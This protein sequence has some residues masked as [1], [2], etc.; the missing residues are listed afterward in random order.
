MTRFLRTN[1]NR[2]LVA[3]I[4]AASALILISIGQLTE[5][6]AASCGLSATDNNFTINTVGGAISGSADIN[7]ACGVGANATGGSATAVGNIARATGAQAT[8]VGSDAR[9]TKNGSTAIGSLSRATGKDSTAIGI[10]AVADSDHS[11]SVG[12]TTGQASGPQA[13]QIGA[14]AGY[15]TGNYAIAIGAGWQQFTGAAARGPLSVAIG[16]GD[17]GNVNGVAL[18]AASAEGLLGIAIGTASVANGAGGTTVGWGSMA[19]G[20]DS[21]AFGSNAQANAA[22]SI[23]IGGYGFPGAGKG[24]FVASD[25]VAAIAIGT[26]AQISAG[27][28]NAVAIGLG[29]KAP[30]Y[31]RILVTEGIRRQRLELAI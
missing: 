24:A 26:R 31:C 2:N 30:S 19:N 20:L 8:A 28:S 5:A 29:A 6:E 1:R 9:A 14:F 23:A 16:S 11:V 22:N 17:N 13:I 7:V 10:F 27:A 4:G 3:K 25:A 21:T 18:S 15:Q 12:H